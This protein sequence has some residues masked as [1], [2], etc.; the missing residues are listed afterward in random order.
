VTQYV[1][2]VLSGQ[3]TPDPEIGRYLLDL[4][5]A[6]PQMDATD[7]DTLLTSHMNDLLMVTYLSNLIRTQL[8]LNEKL[9]T[10]L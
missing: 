5:N 6:V 3:Q 1:E 10:V 9:T 8:H 2:E 4:T 7:F